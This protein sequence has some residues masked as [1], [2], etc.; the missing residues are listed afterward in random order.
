MS[1]KG[2]AEE[3][4][5][6]STT[7][8]EKIDTQYWSQDSKAPSVTGNELL[9]YKYSIVVGE[10]REL[11]RR[12]FM[13]TSTT[14]NRLRILIRSFLVLF[15]KQHFSDRWNVSFLHKAPTHLKN[16]ITAAKL[17]QHLA[18]E[19]YSQPTLESQKKLVSQE[20]THLHAA[21]VWKSNHSQLVLQ[22]RSRCLFIIVS[23]V[24]VNILNWILAVRR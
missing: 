17:M 16:T 13:H 7:S 5:T 19:L 22:R 1:K 8:W 10:K 11:D 2:W 20:P 14:M 9:N 23:D 18:Y 6:R 3:S 21:M 15:G 12:P 24:S 4:E